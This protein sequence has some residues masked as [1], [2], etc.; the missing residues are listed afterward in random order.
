MRSIWLGLKFRGAELGFGDAMAA[1][2]EHLNPRSF[3]WVAELPQAWEGVRELRLRV[4]DGR[5]LTSGV[6]LPQFCRQEAVLGTME[7]CK[8]N[9][10]LL[11][12]TLQVM[13]DHGCIFTPPLHLLQG[14]ALEFMARN[15]Y[16]SPDDL[17]GKSS[18]DGWGMKRMMGCLKRK[19]MRRETPRA[20]CSN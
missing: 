5:S 6:L 17:P 15:G 20:P 18:A 1:A 11:Q 13:A 8:L 10:S 12:V 14:A 3:D 19:F 7:C 4:V 16:P 9:A 2:L